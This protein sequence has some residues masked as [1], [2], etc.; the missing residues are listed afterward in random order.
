MRPDIVLLAAAKRVD[1]SAERESVRVATTRL[2]VAIE[3]ARRE[4]NPE[5]PIAAERSQAAKRHGQLLEA[6]ALDLASRAVG[7]RSRRN[8]DDGH[9]ESFFPEIVAHDEHLPRL[10]G[11]GAAGAS[12]H[13]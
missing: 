13:R 1:Q 7:G 10:G 3:H 12:Q 4:S 5:R 9:R 8:A 11:R 6:P 2:I